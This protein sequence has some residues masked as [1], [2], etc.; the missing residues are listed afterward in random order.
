MDS[1]VRGFTESWN[2][3]DRENTEAWGVEFVFTKE[4]YIEKNNKVVY[5]KRTIG[6]QEFRSNNQIGY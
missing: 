4:K 6:S 5:A 2:Y 3:G 1:R